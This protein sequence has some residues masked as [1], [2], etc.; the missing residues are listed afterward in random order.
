MTWQQRHRHQAPHYGFPRLALPCRGHGLHDVV[1]PDA[2]F[3]E[4]LLGLNQTGRSITNADVIALDGLSA[5]SPYTYDT[6]VPN[7]FV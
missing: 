1:A 5:A 6:L 7:H 4:G 2:P 3:D